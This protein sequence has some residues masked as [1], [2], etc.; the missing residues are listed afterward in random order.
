MINKILIVVSVILI[1]LGL[2]G[3]KTKIVK[4]KLLFLCI[5]TAGMLMLPISQWNQFGVKGGLRQAVFQIPALLCF[6]LLLWN[7]C[8]KNELTSV[9]ELAGIRQRMPFLYTSAV[10]FAIILIGFPATGTFYGIMYSVLGLLGGDFGICTYVGL[11]GIVAGIAIS[12]ML[13]FSILKQA[14]LSG[15]VRFQ[16]PSK[17]VAVVFV[18]IALLLVIL[19]IF[20]NQ[21]ISVIDKPIEKIFS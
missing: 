20:Q 1:F 8:K 19:C 11:A 5:S 9:E 21:V 10:V 16:S 13:T 17:C 12:A 4:K 14:Y 7:I 18:I 6:I 3:V 2:R 15:S